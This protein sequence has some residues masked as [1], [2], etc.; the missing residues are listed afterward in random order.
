M[1]THG[2]TKTSLYRM[3]QN[4]KNRCNNPNVDHYPNYGAR[5]IKVC[6]EWMKGYL[7]FRKWALENGYVEGKSI[8]RNN[9]NDNY[10]PENCKFIELKDQVHN[11]TV[12]RRITWNGKTLTP[13]EWSNEL[14]IPFNAL[15]IRITRKWSIEKIFTKPFRISSPRK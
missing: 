2:E 11:K 13:R 6:E 15:Q 8:E 7:Y 1:K 5:G 14:G 9:V 3:Y 10:C 12:S 4:M